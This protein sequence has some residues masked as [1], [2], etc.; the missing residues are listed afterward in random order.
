VVATGGEDAN[1]G[2]ATTG[3]GAELKGR[4]GGVA[5]LWKATAVGGSS[6]SPSSSSRGSG[7]IGKGGGRDAAANDEIGVGA[8]SSERMAC[9]RSADDEGAGD[10]GAG[11]DAGAAAT[12]DDGG[13][14]LGVA[15]DF[16]GESGGADL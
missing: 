3:G 6:S 8:G 4:L 5:M 12:G 13:P 7:S 16:I 1:A 11:D 15:A 9:D 10:E 14:D 2:A